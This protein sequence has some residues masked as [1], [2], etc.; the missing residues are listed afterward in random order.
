M[1]RKAGST[2]LSVTTSV[3]GSGAWTE[4]ILFARNEGCPFR[5]LIR[6]I[7]NLKSADVSGLPLVNLTPSRSVKVY[8]LPLRIDLPLGGEQRLRLGGVLALEL[9]ERLVHRVAD[10]AGE[11]LVEAAGIE[12]LE[13]VGHAVDD[14]LVADR[15]GRLRG[16]GRLGSSGRGRGQRRRRQAW[17]PRLAWPLRRA[18]PLRQAWRPRRASPGR[19]SRPGAWAGT[20]PTTAIIRSARSARTGIRDAGPTPRMLPPVGAVG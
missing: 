15:R 16:L 9:E 17:R 1:P 6:S 8:T 18:W 14:L 7:A 19:W 10:H 13:V 4:A 12:R 20:Q 5:F 3:F 11:G 2:S